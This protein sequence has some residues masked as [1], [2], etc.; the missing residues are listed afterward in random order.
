MIE[1]LKLFLVYSQIWLNLP[2]NDCLFFYILPWMMGTL[3]TS[4]KLT[5]KSAGPPKARICVAVSSFP[6][7]F[8]R[9]DDDLELVVGYLCS[10]ALFFPSFFLSCFAFGLPRMSLKLEISSSHGRQLLPLL[11]LVPTIFARFFLLFLLISFLCCCSLYI[12]R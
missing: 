1:D 7:L 2:R 11:H 9:D 5:Q 4:Q 12:Q 8:L 10:F 3:A 6:D